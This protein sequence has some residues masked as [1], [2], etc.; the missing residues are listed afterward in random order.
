MGLGALME[1]IDTT[2]ATQ[3]SSGDAILNHLCRWR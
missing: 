3:R 2:V 1:E